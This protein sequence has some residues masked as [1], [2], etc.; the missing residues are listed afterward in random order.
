MVLFVHGGSVPSVPDYDLDY[1]DYSWMGHLAEAAF[2]AFAM[3][4]TGYGRSP[5]PKMDDACNMNEADQAIVRP[6]PL[7]APCE[8]SY[9]F[10]STTVQSDWDEID[11]VVDYIRAAGGR[12]G[13][14]R[15]MVGRRPPHRRL[16][17]RAGSLGAIRFL[18]EP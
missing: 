5:R 13:E 11:T 3:D 1:E 18:A 7:A 10:R 6:H 15:G 14:P 4:H 17:S 9:P 8:P 2:D 12:A 16:A